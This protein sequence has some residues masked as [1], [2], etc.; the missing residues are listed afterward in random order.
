[1]KDRRERERQHADCPVRYAARGLTM[2]G[3]TDTPCVYC[4]DAGTR[5]AMPDAIG[6]TCSRWRRPRKPIPVNT[7]KRRHYPARNTPP[8]EDS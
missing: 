7:S 8:F 2:C 3:A 1:M 6:L 5:Y 4:A